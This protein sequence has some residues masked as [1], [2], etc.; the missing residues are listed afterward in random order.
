MHVVVTGASGFSGSHIVPIL[1]AQNHVVTAVVRRIDPANPP[2]FDVGQRLQVVTGDLSQPDAL[3]ENVDAIIHTAARSPGPTVSV[4]DM[5]RDNVRLMEHLTR[6]ACRSGARLFVFFSSLSVYGEI[7]QGEVNERTAIV[8][9]DAYGMT[10]LIGERLLEELAR[11]IPCRALS[12]RLPAIIGPAARRN[13][14]STV[15]E[16]ANAGRDIHIYHPEAPFNNALHVDDLCRFV[17]DLLHLDW[18]GHDVMTLGAGGVTTVQRAV[19][20]LISGVRSRSK[21]IVNDDS[22]RPS[23]TISSDHAMQRYGYRPRPIDTILLQFAT[24]GRS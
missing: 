13:W 5:V 18:T 15:L 19:E 4:A 17:A 14:L 20:M 21:V 2:R 7:R 12:L 1:L 11:D 6:Y 8:N 9:P 16:A 3:P 23:F 22:S 10:K 24:E